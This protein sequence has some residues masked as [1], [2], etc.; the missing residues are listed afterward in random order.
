[1]SG[2]QP[3]Y[4]CGELFFNILYKLYPLLPETVENPQAPVAVAAGYCV[5]VAVLFKGF[6]VDIIAG[7]ETAV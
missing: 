5:Y 4:N 1:L 6:G 2:F 3:V 7:T